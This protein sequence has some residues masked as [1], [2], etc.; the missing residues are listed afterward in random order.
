MGRPRRGFGLSLVFP[1]LFISDADANFDRGRAD[2]V[3]RGLPA[4]EDPEE[5]YRYWQYE[6]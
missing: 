6:C 2:S 5:L 4:A 1:S 3:Y